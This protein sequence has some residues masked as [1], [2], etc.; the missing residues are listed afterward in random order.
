MHR[1]Q[2]QSA[3]LTGSVHGI[4]LSCER[5]RQLEVPDECIAFHASVSYA[6]CWPFRVRFEQDGQREDLDECI[7]SNYLPFNSS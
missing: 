1:I 3:S 2:S 6:S 7:H 5:L 4:E